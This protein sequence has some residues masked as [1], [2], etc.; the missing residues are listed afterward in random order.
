MSD[1]VVRVLR[2]GLASNCRGTSLGNETLTLFFG[3]CMK[4]LLLHSFKRRNVVTR[5]TRDSQLRY[6]VYGGI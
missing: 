3:I 5:N 4:R 1:F 2:E 6:A